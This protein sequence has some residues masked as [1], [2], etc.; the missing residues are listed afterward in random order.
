MTIDNSRKAHEAV[1]LIKKATKRGCQ[2]A[3]DGDSVGLSYAGNNTRRGRVGRGLAHTLDTGSRQGVVRAGRIRRLT[4]REC[5]RL[6]GFGDDMIDRILAVTS[7]SQAYKQ[8]GNAVTVNV[9]HAIGLRLRAVHE[10]LQGG[11]GHQ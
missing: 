9:I 1:L 5:L 7:D 11:E 6:Q 2:E 4:P 10:D 8:A 3:R